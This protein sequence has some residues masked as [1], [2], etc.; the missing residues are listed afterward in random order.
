MDPKTQAD[1]YF[2]DCDVYKRWLADTDTI[3]LPTRFVR[4]QRQF[5]LQKAVQ[6]GPR[7]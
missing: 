3:F 1:E 7:K 4:S 5:L 6:H 2:E